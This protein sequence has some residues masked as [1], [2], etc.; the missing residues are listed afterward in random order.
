MSPAASAAGSVES[1][2]APVVAS[3]PERSRKSWR[4][5]SC[6]DDTASAPLSTADSAAPAASPAAAA[7]A[8]P[9]APAAAP[10]AEPIALPAAVPASAPVAVAERVEGEV[11]RW[12][13]VPSTRVGSGSPESGCAGDDAAASSTTGIS[14]VSPMSREAGFSA[15]LDTDWN[16]PRV[17]VLKARVACSSSAAAGESTG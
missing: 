11:G 17:G 1:T 2:C 14:S 15:A 12:R 10:A 16:P 6:A 8:A 13:V 4:A 9:A 7:L 3:R 5:F